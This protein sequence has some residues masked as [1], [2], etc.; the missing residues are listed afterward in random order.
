MTTALEDATALAES[1]ATKRLARLQQEANKAPWKPR[2]IYASS[3]GECDR[4]MVYAFVAYDQKSPFSTDGVAAMQ[5]G[6]MEEAQ[7]LKELLSD[8]FSPVETQVSMDDE[9]LF[10]TGKIDGKLKWNGRKTPFEIKRLK[11]YAFDRITTI[12]DLRGDPFLTKY[13]RQLTAYL[14]LH[15]EEAGLFILSDGCGKRKYL[16]IALD[17]DFAETE[18][19]Q[20]CERVKAALEGIQRSGARTLDQM[21]L[22]DRIPYSSKICGFCNW[23]HICLPQLNFGEGAQIAEPEMEAKVKR[24]L[25]LKPML[26]ELEKLGKELK[27][28][29]E[30]KDIT[31]AGG[32]VLTGKWIDVKGNPAPAPRPAYR[33][34]KWDVEPL[35]TEAVTA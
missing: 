27:A 25:E 34:W 23:N 21:V 18:V 7:I 3:L 4:Q 10:L 30:G 5:D 29:V 19:V 13:L 20:R 16:V 8:G 1:L 12:D 32:Y 22:P 33:Y 31:V 26:A 11:P 17:L 15:N 6:Q 24:Y 9:R 35:K 14:Y 28:I 2:K